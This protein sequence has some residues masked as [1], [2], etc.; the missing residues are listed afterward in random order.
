MAVNFSQRRSAIEEDGVYIGGFDL[1]KAILPIRDQGGRLDTSED[2]I[3]RINAGVEQDWTPEEEAKLLRKLDLRVLFPCC[4]IYFLAY[5]DRVNLGNVKILQSGTPSSITNS[6][7]GAIVI[8]MA[9]VKN[10][11][12]LLATRALLGVPE[13]GVGK[14]PRAPPCFWYRPRERALR[15]AVFHASNA[16][17]GAVSAFFAAGIDHLNG[18]GGIKS[19]QWVFLIEGA[20]PVVCAA[21]L[22]FILLSFPED[23]KALTDRE[24]YIAINRFGRGATRSTD[25]TWDTSAFIRIMT[26]PST[27]CFFVSYICV[28]IIAVSQATF[29]PSIFHEFMEFSTTKSNIYTAAVY[30]ALIPPYVLWSLHSDWVRERLWHFLIPIIL[31]VPCYAVWTF[32]AFHSEASSIKPISLYGV[33]ILGKLIAI[34]QPIILSYRS[35]TLYGAAEQAVGTSAAVASLSIASIIAPQMLPDSDAPLY[36]SGFIAYAENAQVSDA[37][38]ARMHAIQAEETARQLDSEKLKGVEGGS[39]GHVEEIE[40]ASRK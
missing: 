10:S 8:A 11:A 36:Q 21:P 2:R 6:T 5:L 16:L 28:A 29:L 3:E 34:S 1:R 33:A 12:G 15:L 35:S 23:S 32:F 13:S 31:S 19:W 17:A 22:Y 40:L 27:Y 30:L 38:M 24:R 39:E 37:A 4:V 7:G 18:R 25:V 14:H 9:G 20:I 26:R